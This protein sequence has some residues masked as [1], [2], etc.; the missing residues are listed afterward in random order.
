MSLLRYNFESQY[1]RQ[2]NEIIVI[3]P[4]RP[5]NLYAE[6]FFSQ[7]KKYPVLWLLH[8]TYG[9]CT[10]WIRKSNIERYACERNI[11]VVLPCAMNSDYVNWPKFGMGYDYWDYFFKELMPLVYH[12]LPISDRREDNFLAGLSM[13]GL[14]AAMYGLNR[15]ELFDACGVFSYPLID[16]EH[17]VDPYDGDKMPLDVAGLEGMGKRNRN[18]EE[19]MGGREAFVHSVYHV[20]EKFFQEYPTGKLPRMFFVCGTEDFFWDS[21][22]IMKKAILEKGYEDITFLEY[23]G[24]AHEWETWDRAVKAFLDFCLKK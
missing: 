13:G 24:L 1:L 17:N 6:E 19:N 10:D 21:Y 3:L 4:D 20:W 18:M 15:P 22:C 23:E 8:G 14:G 5:K 2:N 11:A 12:W 7:P 9:D 16:L